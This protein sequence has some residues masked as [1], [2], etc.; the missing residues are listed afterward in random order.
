MTPR[1]GKAIR[2]R[3]SRNANL[4][5]VSNNHGVDCIAGHYEIKGTKIPMIMISQ[6]EYFKLKEKIDGLHV[7][8]C[9]QRKRGAKSKTYWCEETKAAT[10]LLAQIREA[11]DGC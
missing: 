9:S 8:I 6:E 10:T 1:N 4:Q 5:S 7:K 11:V 3:T 2:S